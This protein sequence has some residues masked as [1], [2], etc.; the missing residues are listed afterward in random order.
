MALW[1]MAFLGSTPLGGPIVGTV[2]QYL[3]PRAAL[4]L[5]AV[6]C[7]TAAAIGVMASARVRRAATQH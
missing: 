3:S 4:A 5:G 6:A 2:G 1:A 7:L